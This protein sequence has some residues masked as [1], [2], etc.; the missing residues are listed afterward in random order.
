MAL[1]YGHEKTHEMVPAAICH[2]EEMMDLQDRC[3]LTALSKEMLSNSLLG[4]QSG[5]NP[6]AVALQWYRP[7]SEVRRFG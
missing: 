4:I 5:P 1:Y 3:G 2:L 7:G 6:M